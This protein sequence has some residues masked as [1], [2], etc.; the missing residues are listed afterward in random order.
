MADADPHQLDAV[1]TSAAADDGSSSNNSLLL[2]ADSRET[3][4]Q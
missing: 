2:D 1:T 3:K 4:E